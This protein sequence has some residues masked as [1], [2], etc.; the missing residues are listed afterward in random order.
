MALVE[1]I[2]NTAHTPGA[3]NKPFPAGEVV[4]ADKRF[5][6]EGLAVPVKTEKESKKDKADS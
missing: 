1:M 4:K 6:D 2:F 5:I 3:G